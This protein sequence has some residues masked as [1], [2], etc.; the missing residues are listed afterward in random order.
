MAA[1]TNLLRGECIEDPSKIEIP[2]EDYVLGFL[3]ALLEEQNLV[4]ILPPRLRT[5]HSPHEE[6]VTITSP[7]SQNPDQEVL[8]G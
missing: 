7:S 3:T 4:S 2:T 1:D 8:C 5:P 6:S